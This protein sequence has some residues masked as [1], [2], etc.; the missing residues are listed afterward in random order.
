MVAKGRVLM[1]LDENIITLT[2]V[3]DVCTRKHSL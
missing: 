2:V 1:P 3:C